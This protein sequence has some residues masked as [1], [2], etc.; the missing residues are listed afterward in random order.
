MGTFEYGD[1]PYRRVIADRTLLHLQ[2]VIVSKLRRTERFLFQVDAEDLSRDGFWMSPEIPLRFHYDQPQPPAV[3]PLWLG[4]L[5]EAANSVSGLRIL[6]EPGSLET[7]E[8]SA[9]RSQHAALIGA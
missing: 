3:N 1:G 8:V 9:G 6:P 7:S 5:V 4:L 2:I